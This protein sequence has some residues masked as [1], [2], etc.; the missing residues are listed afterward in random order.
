M[1]TITKCAL[2]WCDRPALGDTLCEVHRPWYMPYP[3][4]QD[5]WDEFTDTTTGRSDELGAEVQLLR[6]EILDAWSAALR[7]MWYLA[8]TLALEAWRWIRSSSAR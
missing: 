5:E 3:D 8:E 6:E 4:V 1:S 2:D 7:G